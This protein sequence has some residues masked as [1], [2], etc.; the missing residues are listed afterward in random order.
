V[1]ARPLTDD[2]DDASYEGVVDV[3]L[4]VKE[5]RIAEIRAREH[6]PL[7]VATLARAR[8]LLSSALGVLALRDRRGGDVLPQSLLVGVRQLPTQAL[9]SRGGSS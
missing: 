3:G 7:G 5:A 4:G 6:D 8:K 9:E 1:L 2:G